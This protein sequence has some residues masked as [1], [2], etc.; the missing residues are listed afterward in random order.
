MNASCKHYLLAVGQAQQNLSEKFD[1]TRQMLSRGMKENAE[2]IS[3]AHFQ[4]FAEY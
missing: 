3:R 1:L 2:N 4:K